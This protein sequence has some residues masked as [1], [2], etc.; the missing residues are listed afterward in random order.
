M[1]LFYKSVKNEEIIK[2]LA[3]PFF[4]CSV[5]LFLYFLGILPFFGIINLLTMKYSGLAENPGLVAK[6]L[7]IF[8]YSFISVDY[9]LQWKRMKSSY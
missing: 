4:I 1:L 7:S 3:F 2:P 8:I 6:S 9:Y 5:A